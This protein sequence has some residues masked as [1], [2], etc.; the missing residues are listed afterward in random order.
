MRAILLL[1]P[2]LVPVAV[3]GAVLVASPAGADDRRAS[4]Q[5][6]AAVVA[7]C[8]VTSDAAGSWG[9]IDMGSVPGLTGQ[10]ASGTLI[11]GGVA[12]ITV[13]CTPETSATLAA[14]AG[15]NASGGRRRLRRA[16]AA[17]TLPYQLRVGDGALAW[18]AQPVTLAFPAGTSRRTLPVS[19]TATLP[20][21]AAAGAYADT[22]R[23]TLTF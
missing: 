1:L 5:V 18:D 20:G 7:G 6:S 19:A 23:V 8:T 15:E 11:A 10:A 13:G 14:D 22:V 16:G 2:A 3:L 4:F 21:P 9:R 12:G 17:D